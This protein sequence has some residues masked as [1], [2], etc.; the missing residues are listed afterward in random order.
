MR[1]LVLGGGAQGTAAAFDLL[2]TGEAEEVVVADK[3]PGHLPPFLEPFAGERLTPLA[4]DAG[5]VAQLRGALSGVDA[6]LCA[7]PYYFNL[8]ATREAIRAG[9]HYC[10]LGG[11]TEIVREQKG[12]HDAAAEARVSVVPDCGLAPGIVNVLAQAGIEALDETRS[13]RIWVGGLPQDPRPP[14]NYQIVYSIE[15]VLDYY[16]TDALVLEGGEPAYVEALTGVEEVEFSD[17]VG[18]L[19]GFHTGGGISTLPFRHQGRIDEM[20]YKTLRYP[21]HA[22]IMRAIRDLGLLDLE[23]VEVDGCQVVPRRLFVERVGPQLEDPEGRDLVAMRVQVEG[24]K[25]QLERT[26]RFDLLDR[27]DEEN[28][29]TAMMRTTGYSLA[30]TARMQADGRIPAKGVHTP[31]ECVPVEPFLTELAQRGVHVE[32]TDF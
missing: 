12:L 17:P 10:D 7:L 26:V 6:V 13:V 24:R 30:I 20:F 15:G 16:T 4:L 18:R 32:R 22:E 2:R 29:I 9:A 27:Y 3:E 25:D 19:E 28:G 31:D 11:N 21:G 5:D 14:L 8:P 1:F 23:A